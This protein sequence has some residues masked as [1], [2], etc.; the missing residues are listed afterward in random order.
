MAVMRCERHTEAAWS[1]VAT[2]TEAMMCDCT[3]IWSNL[4]SSQA[5]I[6]THT[7][8]IIYIKSPAW[9][10]LCQEWKHLKIKHGYPLNKA[11]KSFTDIETKI[12]M[13]RFKCLHTN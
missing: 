12:N 8:T 9:T 1:S 5:H 2:Y 11:Y 13:S 4:T 3:R 6:Y 10:S 7:H